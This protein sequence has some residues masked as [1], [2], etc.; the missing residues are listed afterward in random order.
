MAW[1][2]LLTNSEVISCGLFVIDQQPEGIYATNICQLYWPSAVLCASPNSIFAERRLCGRQQD[3]NRTRQRVPCPF[4][5]DAPRGSLGQTAISSDEKCNSIN[6][7]NILSQQGATITASP[8]SV[9]LF[10]VPFR[11]VVVLLSTAWFK[12]VLQREKKLLHGI[13]FNSN[14]NKK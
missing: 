5:E 4:V 13:G 6:F 14:F 2:F 11:M 8:I 7:S 1:V 3:K 12:L 9:G 10:E